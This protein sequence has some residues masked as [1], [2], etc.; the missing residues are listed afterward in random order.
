MVNLRKKRGRL[1]DSDPQPQGGYSQDLGVM[2]GSPDGTLNMQHMGPHGGHME[3][4]MGMPEGQQMPDGH[5]MPEGQQMGQHAH[6]GPHDSHLPPAT[7]V[8]QQDQHGFAPSMPMH[9]MMGPYPGPHMGSG[10]LDPLLPLHMDPTIAQSAGLMHHMAAQMLQMD[11]F[12]PMG[13]MVPYGTPAFDMGPTM[14][15]QMPNPGQGV[16][17][18]SQPQSMDPMHGMHT[19]EHAHGMH[20]M[21]GPHGYHMM[22]PS[23]HGMSGPPGSHPGHFMQAHMSCA[24]GNAPPGQAMQGMPGQPTLGSPPYAMQVMPMPPLGMHPPPMQGM[25]QAHAPDHGHMM[26][27]MPGGQAQDPGPRPQGFPPPH[28]MHNMQGLLP[29]Q[30]LPQF[31]VAPPVSSAPEALGSKPMSA[32]QLTGMPPNMQGMPPHVHGPPYHHMGDVQHHMGGTDMIGIPQDAM[33]A[34]SVPA[35]GGGMTPPVSAPASMPL[36]DTPPLDQKNPTIDDTGVPAA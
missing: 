22:H 3:G 7:H 9:E 28:L 19:L 34:P 31:F 27:G 36:Q 5:Q 21:M 35:D 33:A 24:P 18:M 30:T 11:G 32:P 10:T 16:H 2:M 14:P 20:P 26:Q 25:Q 1:S 6:M 13:H 8:I 23:V 17:G 4:H 12:S 29:G 15:P